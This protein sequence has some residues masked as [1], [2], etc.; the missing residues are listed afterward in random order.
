MAT[1][2][3]DWNRDGFL[4]ISDAKTLDRYEELEKQ[5]H[6]VSD[7]EIFFA[8]SD[9]QLQEGLKKSGLSSEQIYHFGAGMF[10]TIEGH[11][12][13]Y[14]KI[15]AIDENIRKECDPKEVYWYEYNN[16]ESFINW[17]G[18]TDAW[19]KVLH[20]FGEEICSTIHRLKS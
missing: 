10:G 19:N 14:N 11:D 2:K 5:K 8:F 6:E 12:R 9:E 17:E 20:I 16:H 15:K 7:K 13:L 3:R 4:V 1:F 18:D